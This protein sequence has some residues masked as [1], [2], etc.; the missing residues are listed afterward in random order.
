VCGVVGMKTFIRKDYKFWVCKYRGRKASIVYPCLVSLKRHGELQY[1]VNFNGKPYCVNKDKF[2]R[3]RL[4][5]P[6]LKEFEKF[7]LPK[8]IYLGELYYGEGKT[9]EDFYTFLSRK[10]SDELRLDVFGVYQLG[11]RTGIMTEETVRVLL[12]IKNGK[13]CRKA[14]FWLVRNEKE[15]KKLIDKWI[16]K[17][18]YEGLVV[19]N[20]KAWWLPRASYNWVKIK[21]KSREQNYK[22][23]KYGWWL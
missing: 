1:I 5:F 7:N 2:G 10:T 17:E 4:D 8:G 16:I 3:H 13:H 12:K 18:G 23:G 20:M 15:L 9:D 21:K 6:A 19:R 14:K 22:N 11:K